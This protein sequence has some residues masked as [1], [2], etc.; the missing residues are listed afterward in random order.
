MNMYDFFVFFVCFVFLV[1]WVSEIS[2]LSSGALDRRP[3]DGDWS[4]QNPK[5]PKPQNPVLKKFMTIK[6]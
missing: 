6:Y 1:F 3:Q 2:S 4:S 5:T